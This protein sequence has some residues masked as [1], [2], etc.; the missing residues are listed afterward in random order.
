MDVKGEFIMR[1]FIKRLRTAWNRLDAWASRVGGAK[2]GWYAALAAL[3]VILG[4]ASYAYRNRGAA[5]KGE[6]EAPRAV[7]AAVTQALWNRCMNT[8]RE[9]TGEVPSPRSAFPLT[10]ICWSSPLK[11][12]A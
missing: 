2:L 10:I 11:S 8:C 9:L 5:R 7:M 4:S 6:A 12:P 3:L 1:T